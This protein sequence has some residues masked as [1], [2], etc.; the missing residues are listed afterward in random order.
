M[1]FA[2]VNGSRKRGLLPR[3]EQLFAKRLRPCHGVLQPGVK[4][5]GLRLR[6]TLKERSKVMKTHAASHDEHALIAKRCKRSTHGQVRVRVEPFEEREL[7]HGDRRFG[8]RNFERNERP[9]IE[10]ALVVA[11]R[12]EACMMQQFF[13]PRRKL[14]SPGGRP[15]ELVGFLG[16]PVVI[17]EQRRR[18]VRHERGHA[19]F[20]MRRND[21]NG[22][23]RRR[24]NTRKR[25]QVVEQ[26]RSLSLRPKTKFDEGPWPA[27]MGN[28]DR[29]HSI[30]RNSKVMRHRPASFGPREPRPQPIRIS[31][32]GDSGS[33]FRDSGP[34]SRSAPRCS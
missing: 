23:E 14:R 16:K 30:H 13:D 2:W 26:L 7:K 33:G 21:E 34:S 22:R 24:R 28:E 12:G 29:R 19:L 1:L 11:R 25:P 3:T 10:A 32:L 15:R 31:S 9:V 20:P 5:F 27:A 4:R 18:R 6:A 8:K 17:E